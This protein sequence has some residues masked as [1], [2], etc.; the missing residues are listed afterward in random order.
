MTCIATSMGRGNGW[1]GHLTHQMLTG[2][3]W[4]DS[5]WSLQGLRVGSVLIWVPVP[6]YGALIYGKL[7]HY[8]RVRRLDRLGGTMVSND[9]R[10]SRAPGVVPHFHAW[11]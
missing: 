4:G 6:W 3:L 9:L 11:W 10:A 1:R 7:G 2:V 8:L 5:G